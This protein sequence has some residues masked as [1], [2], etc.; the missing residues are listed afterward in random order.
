MPTGHKCWVGLCRAGAGA[1]SLHLVP[2]QALTWVVAAVPTECPHG[3]ASCLCTEDADTAPSGSPRFSLLKSVTLREQS[4]AWRAEGNRGESA[5]LPWASPHTCQLWLKQSATSLYPASP[6]TASGWRPLHQFDLALWT[7]GPR[8]DVTDRHRAWK[9]LLCREA[10]APLCLEGV[11]ELHQG[12]GRTLSP[13]VAGVARRWDTREDRR[14]P[15]EPR[16]RQAP[17]GS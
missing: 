6:D 13:R 2:G 8:G 7:E 5:S 12:E 3:L 4:R 17:L 16:G 9:A 1:W 14:G 15:G 10:R 11:G